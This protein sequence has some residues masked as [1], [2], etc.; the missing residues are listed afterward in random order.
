MKKQIVWLGALLAVLVLA[1]CGNKAPQGGN[2]PADETGAANSTASKDNNSGGMF[3]GSLKDLMTRG[4]D[5]QC[6]WSNSSDTAKSSGAVYVSGDKF[7][8][9]FSYTDTKTNKEMKSYILND[10]TWIYQWSALSNVGTKMKMDEVRKLAEDFQKNNPG[11]PAGNQG[12]ENNINL[13][14]KLDYN[15]QKWNADASKFVLPADIQF[16]D[17]SQMMNNLPKAA[18]GNSPVDVCQMC[19]RLPAEGKAACLSNCKK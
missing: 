2:T 7:Y 11:G 16:N 17:L 5:T 6:T 1:G 14:N 13:D 12:G 19:D 18:G 9:E 4:G 8:Q 10:G 3:S 15:C